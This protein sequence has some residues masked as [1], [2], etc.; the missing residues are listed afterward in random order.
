[1]S[2]NRFGNFTTFP[3]SIDKPSSL[4]MIE[5]LACV[6]PATTSNI[7]CVNV[8]KGT[9]KL[10]SDK[11]PPGSHGYTNL[12]TSS[13][14]NSVLSYI[15]TPDQ[16]EIMTFKVVDDCVSFQG[17][18][19][20]RNYGNNMWFSNNGTRIFLSN[21]LSLNGLTLSPND[22]LGHE[23]IGK[24]TYTSVS[25]MYSNAMLREG[26]VADGNR[27]IMALHDDVMDKVFYFNWPDLTANGTEAIPSPDG[28]SIVRPISLQY[29]QSDF[30]YALVTYKR[31]RDS[32][33]RTGVA[34]LKYYF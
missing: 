8:V 28:Y 9:Q 13:P 2:I 18:V 10:C 21:G 12:P 25:Q 5:N 23:A 24:D 19:S 14:S 20:G 11:I 16:Q 29:C 27:P 33:L 15:V 31:N 34:Y 4:F 6:T 17:A 22:T 3:V 30:A 7:L 1:M 32:G 26:L